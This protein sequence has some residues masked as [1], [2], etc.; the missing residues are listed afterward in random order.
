[1]VALV[2]GAW[3]PV[4]AAEPPRARE[5]EAREH[6][7]TGVD[8]S[9]AEAWAAA[10]AE[11]LRAR[12]LFP[13]PK[14]TVDAAI[15]LRHLQRH[16]EA[17]EMVEALL[18][19]FPDMPA[20]SRAAAESEAADLR[21]LVSLL[22][23]TG[24]EAGTK[25]AV[26]GR[27]RGVL[28]LNRP[29]RLAAG[30]HTVR[31]TAEG[32]RSHEE[33]VE[34]RLGE[35]VRLAVEL[36]ALPAMLAVAPVPADAEVLV[37]GELIGTGPRELALVAGPH[38]LEIRA[39]GFAPAFRQV[40]LGRGERVGLPVTLDPADAAL[41]RRFLGVHLEFDGGALLVP[42]FGGDVV[43]SCT[44][45]CTKKLGTGGHGALRAGYTLPVG[46]GFGVT[47][48]G[49]VAGQELTERPLTFTPVGLAP[50][51]GTSHDGLHLRGLVLGGFVGYSRGERFR[52]HLR[53]GGGAL[54]SRVGDNRM[55]RFPG[56]P[57]YEV[58]PLSVSRPQTFGF[59]EPEVRFGV[60]VAARVEISIG[61][62]AP[63]LFRSTRASWNPTQ[64]VDAGSNV[65]G[66]F[67]GE[68]LV[69]SPLCAVVPDLG[70]RYDL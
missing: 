67:P 6:F 35:T 52:V 14:A 36:Q 42:S 61:V 58:G 45:A 48:G 55:A 39:R 46:L 33:R 43:E 5:V 28:P 31:L 20:E 19:E 41:R 15:C 13:N 21:K 47:V 11:F 44:G 68:S 51:D 12:E 18:G 69:G 29:I 49:L 63:I 62:G 27:E 8:L 1:V 16:D 65:K 37:D 53:A 7:K 22:D 24:P 38:R 66:T 23:V 9:R 17:L 26:D 30:R 32:F 60:R 59:L 70:L 10:L 3:S 56:T 57:A 40:T 64:L 2:A 4:S 50:R 25:V 54:F 34:P